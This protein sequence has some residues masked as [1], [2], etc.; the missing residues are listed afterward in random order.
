M[1]TNEGWPEAFGFTI[2]G[3]APVYIAYVEEEGVAQQAG[4]LAGDIIVELNGENV[5][6][7]S[8]IELI[9][10]ALQSQKVPPSLIV[11]SRLR[12]VTLQRR[13]TVT[14][15]I[16]VRGDAPVYI[17]TVE[18]DSP[19]REVGLRS[20]DLVLEIDGVSVRYSSKYEVLELMNQAGLDMTMVVVA[21]GGD[22]RTNGVEEEVHHAHFG[23]SGRMEKRYSKAK[24]FHQQVSNGNGKLCHL[25]NIIICYTNGCLIM[26]G[27]YNN[28]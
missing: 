14:F 5:R 17:R 3:D 28:N 12:T 8:K 25:C 1:S 22:L 26:S 2:E 19:A 24:S 6:R 11:L 20:G 7:C 18:F 13:R 21:A 16:T 4:L 15:G 27:T 10:L 9:A 23:P